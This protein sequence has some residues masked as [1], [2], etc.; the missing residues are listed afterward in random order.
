V[1]HFLR[2]FQLAPTR[3]N[4]STNRHSD[5]IQNHKNRLKLELFGAEER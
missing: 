1:L 4:V 3:L 5:F 2:N